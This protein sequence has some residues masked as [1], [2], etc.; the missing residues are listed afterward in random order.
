M[1]TPRPLVLL[2][3][4]FLLALTVQTPVHAQAQRITD[5]VSL[6]PNGAVSIDNHEGSITVTTWD[7]NAVQY[8]VEIDAPEG[9][10][11]FRNTE[12]EVDHSNRSLRLATT[13]RDRDDDGSWFS[14]NGG[15]IANVHYTIQMPRT[16]RLTIDDHESDITVT[17]LQAALRIDTHE[18]PIQVA[19][20]QGEVTIDSHESRMDLTNLTGA[21]TID[22][23][24]GDITVENLRGALEIDTH[25]GS[26]DV[27]FAALTD[28]VE[29]DTH[30]GRFTL[31]VP[32]DVGFDLRTD[33]ND[34]ADLDAD[35]DI[36]RL[37]IADDDEDEVNYRGAYNG[38]GPRIDLEAHDGRF[39]LRRQ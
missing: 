30:D 20:Q 19:N 10:D 16:A 27:S 25:E 17:G 15:D 2:A 12:I 1:R 32:S 36:A 29:I 11:A 21:L 38:G 14:W 37:R 22:T 5:T 4:V 6:D 24:E 39:T 8:E 26:A 18:G 33:F 7:R 34:D 23:H 31:T 13:Q 3:S 28:D 35:F 9:S